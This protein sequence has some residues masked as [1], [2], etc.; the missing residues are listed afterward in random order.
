M[1]PI[2]CIGVLGLKRCYI[3][4]DN[5]YDDI[6]DDDVDVANG[7]DNGDDH[8]TNEHDENI[9]DNKHDDTHRS[10]ENGDDN[11]QSEEEL[12]PMASGTIR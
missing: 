11:G 9:N 6:K 2:L 7:R 8:V 1:T 10:G 5:E 4:D 12:N 3:T